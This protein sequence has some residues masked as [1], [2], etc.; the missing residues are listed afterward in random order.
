MK[1]L[2]NSDNISNI[3]HHF[4]TQYI[5]YWKY[6]DRLFCAWK[7]KKHDIQDFS[8]EKQHILKI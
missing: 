3:I 7:V 8:I 1:F 6:F 4:I 5:C 2:G